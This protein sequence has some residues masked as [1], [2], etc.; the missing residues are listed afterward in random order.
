MKDL[1]VFTS[2]DWGMVLMVVILMAL[3]QSKKNFV[4]WKKK[5]ASKIEGSL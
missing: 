3:A 2:K 1:F 5:I 4:A